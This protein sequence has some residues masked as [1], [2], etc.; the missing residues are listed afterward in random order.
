M[1]KNHLDTKVYYEPAWPSACYCHY[2]SMVM[3]IFKKIEM[4]ETFGDLL[5]SNSFL[6]SCLDYRFIMRADDYALIVLILYKFKAHI[7][8]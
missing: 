5:A 7:I 6:A 3:N 1:K 2:Q 8:C 4:S